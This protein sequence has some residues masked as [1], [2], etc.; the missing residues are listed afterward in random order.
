MKAFVM[1]WVVLNAWLRML[2]Q[3]LANIGRV[4]FGV[5]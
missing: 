3:T 4:P 5:L 1:G 2:D